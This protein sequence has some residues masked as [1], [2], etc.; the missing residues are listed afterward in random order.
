[1][2]LVSSESRYFSPCTHVLSVPVIFQYIYRDL[3]LLKVRTFLFITAI[4]GV[5]AKIQLFSK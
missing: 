3:V 5:L 2:D 4:N 1:M